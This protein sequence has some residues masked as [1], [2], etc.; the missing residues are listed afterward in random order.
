M[1]QPLKK[2]PEIKRNNIPFFLDERKRALLYQ[3]LALIFFISLVWYL[4]SN[5]QANLA[6]QNIA[7]G[8]S[9]LKNEAGFEIGESIIEYFAHDSYQQALLVGAL[10][11]I[12]VS[13]IGNIFAI[14]IGLLVGIATLSS[15]WPLAQLARSYI[16]LIRNIPLLLQLF[17]WY[18]LF[19]ELLP[20]VRQALE[21]IKGV[22]LSNRGLIIP[23]AQD[24]SGFIWAFVASLLTFCSLPFVKKLALLRLEKTG[25]P[26]PLLFINGAMLVGCPLIVWLSFGA[27]HTFI[28]PRLVGFNFV[29]GHP[30]TPE[31]ASL[32]LGLILYTGAFNAEIVRSGIQ[33]VGKGQWE[34]CRSLGLSKSQGL[35][36]VILPQAM[37]VIIPP[38]T[39]QILNLIK[40]TS[41]AVA[42]GYP[43][44]VSIAN[45]TMNQ[46]GQALEGVALIMGLYL[47]FSLLT[48]LIMNTYN[49]RMALVER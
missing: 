30:L 27:P 49:R 40:N 23:A 32:L 16:E 4:Y 26:L 21:P 25:R 17:F 7:S 12:K 8:F 3:S 20:G 5:V 11:T 42:I 45:T 13:F 31:F 10:N 34:S 9:F 14:L 33:S 2:S 41:L 29:G 43:D 24:P 28:A 48:S 19:T 22:F 6:K 1:E 35:S 39:S 36:L 46:T 44:F 47:S 38:L 15:N 18:A 37:R